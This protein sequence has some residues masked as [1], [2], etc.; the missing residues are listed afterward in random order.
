MATRF[1]SPDATPPTG[2]YEYSLDGDTVTSRSRHD[3]SRLTLALRAKHGLASV[4]D[5][6]SYV[7]EYMCPYLPNGYCTQPSSVNLV[8]IDEVKPRTAAVFGMACVT[9]DVISER[10]AVCAQCRDQVVRGFCMGSCSGLLE[11]IYKGFG[12]RRG[13]LPSDVGIGVCPHDLM[14]GVALASL[15]VAAFPPRRGEMYPDAC[16]RVKKETAL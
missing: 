11:W 13:R 7:Q 9:S 10:L 4:G 3:I 6:F 2:C 15:D 12:G 5:G 1:R 14:F 16:W 8:K